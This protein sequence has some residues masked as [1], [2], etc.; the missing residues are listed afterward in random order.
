MYVLYTNISVTECSPLEIS[1]THWVQWCC[2]KLTFHSVSIS[3]KMTRSTWNW[4][5]FLL[6]LFHLWM[7]ALGD[8]IVSYCFTAVC[9][10]RMFNHHNLNMWIVTV[11]PNTFWHIICFHNSTSFLHMI[12]HYHGEGLLALVQIFSTSVNYLTSDLMAEYYLLGYNAV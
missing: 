2:K 8:T 3:I 6:L 1:A 4:H 10:F 12:Y 11:A 7:S 9:Q 5:K